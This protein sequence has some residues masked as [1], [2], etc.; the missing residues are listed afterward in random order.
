[1]QFIGIVG[2]STAEQPEANQ[3]N[4]AKAV[5]DILSQYNKSDTTI[6]SGGGEGVDRI[7]IDVAKLEEFRTVEYPP[8]SKNWEEYKKRNL[9]IAEECDKV[10]SIALALGTSK[11]WRKNVQCYHCKN[12]GKDTMHEK[13]AG[14]YTGRANGNYEVIVV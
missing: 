3:D 14:C 6:V 11:G 10:Y 2:S 9:Q 13:T 1:M 4:V 12:A 7:A 8:T 5:H